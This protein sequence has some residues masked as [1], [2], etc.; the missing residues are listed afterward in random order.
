MS[1]SNETVSVLRTL[2][3]SC[4]EGSEAYRNAAQRIEDVELQSLFTRYAEQREGF[5]TELNNEV[6]RLGEEP[7]SMQTLTEALDNAW[8]SVRDAV[9]ANDR[10][11]VVA[12]CERGE[13]EAVSKYREALASP[14][15]DPIRAVVARQYEDVQQAHDRIRAIERGADQ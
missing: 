6:T 10:E 2:I 14:L 12:E 1:S 8:T 4:R 15:P 5:L 11:S 7:G 3:E 9:T 13:D